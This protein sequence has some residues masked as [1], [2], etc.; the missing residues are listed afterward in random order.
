M[1]E[2]TIHGHEAQRDLLRGVSAHAF[3]FVGA[4][5]VGRRAVAAWW[6]KWLNC[7]ARTDIPCDRC[8]SCRAA[9]VGAHPD[10]LEKAPNRFTRAGRAALK[11]LLTIDQIVP[12]SGTTADPEPATRWLERP[13][14]FTERLLVLDDAHLMTE[15]AANAFLKTLEEPPRWARIVL[16]APS[17]RALLP[18]LAS[19]VLVVRFGAVEETVPS[20]EGLHPATR[21]GQ[22][23][24]LL[25]TQVD[26]GE[27]L[28][29]KSLTEAYVASLDG[30]L[31][32]ALVAGKDWVKAWSDQPQGG[33]EEY[34]V[35]YIERDAPRLYSRALNAVQRARE[36]LQAYVSPELVATALTLD[37]RASR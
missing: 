4:P 14:R 27:H 6:A 11:P 37:L 26:P 7:E 36:A 30:S 23:G 32:E 28:A 1:H 2:M 16:I 22:F 33:L 12:R 15:S 3:A 24:R 19:R 21:T 10:Y 25:D 29:R 8:E 5:S 9:Q 35:R 13:P 20:L 18:T 17:P 34:L 31:R